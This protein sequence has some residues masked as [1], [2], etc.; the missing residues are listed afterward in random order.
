MTLILFG[1]FHSVLGESRKAVLGAV[2]AKA[3][4]ENERGRLEKATGTQ[5]VA[6]ALDESLNPFWNQR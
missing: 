5:T 4:I 1:T 3:D 6:T 2:K